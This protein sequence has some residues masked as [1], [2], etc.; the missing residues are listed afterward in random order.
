MR[1]VTPMR[2]AKTGYII[3]SAVLCVLGIMLIVNP[4]FSASMLGIICGVVLIAFGIVKLIGYFSKDLYRLAFQY[5]LVFGIVICVLGVLMFVNPGALMTF[6]CITLGISILAD[7]VFKLQ[8]AIDSRKFGIDKWW[9]ILTISIISGV[10]GLILMFRP[11]ESSNV[12]SVILG[13][14]LLCDGILNF[15][16]VITAVKI[17]KNQKPD[18]IEIDYEEGKEE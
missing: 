10:F 8:I 1:S 6:I 16:T 7:S 12:I 5:D 14:S 4:E 2:I 3:I 13:I 15:S 9:L 11:G 18:V 17:V